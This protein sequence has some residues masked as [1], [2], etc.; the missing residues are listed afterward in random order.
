[1]LGELRKQ[2]SGTKDPAGVTGRQK[3]R[4]AEMNRRR[5]RRDAIQTHETQPLTD[6]GRD[7]ER[8][9]S[10][11]ITKSKEP[12]AIVK[13]MKEANGNDDSGLAQKILKD[14]TDSLLRDMRERFRLRKIDKHGMFIEHN[15][16][17][18]LDEAL[19]HLAFPPRTV[20]N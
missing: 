20:I 14:Y 19:N 13:K 16:I 17:I 11:E 6:R 7:L 3:E 9:Y 4:E 15:A 1:E 12:Q 8:R 5:R 2:E 10:I 18:K